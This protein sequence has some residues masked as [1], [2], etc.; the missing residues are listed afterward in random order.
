[1][2]VRIQFNQLKKV[3]IVN[4]TELSL[5]NYQLSIMMIGILISCGKPLPTLDGVNLHGWKN[6][7]N[8]CSGVRASMKET[9]MIQKTKMLSLTETDLVSL[10]GKPDETELY[11]RSEKFYKY[12]FNGGPGCVKDSV[13]TSAM[14]VRFNAMGL[15]KEVVAE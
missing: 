4:R 15:A 13:K 10:I 8:G 5:V 9:M 1:M 14:V 11:K 7:K 2:R 12:Y 3:R 6:D